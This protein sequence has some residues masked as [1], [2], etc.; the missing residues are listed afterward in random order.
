MASKYWI[1][2]YHEILH[3]RKMAQ[4]SDRLWR[5][6]IE[7]FLFAGEIDDGGA[8]P[9]LDDMAWTLH[10]SP[11]VLETDLGELAKVGITDQRGGKWFVTNF[12]KRQEKMDKAEYMRRLRDERQKDE[13]YQGQEEPLPD[14]YQPVTNGNADTDKIRIDKNRTESLRFIPDH[15]ATPAF[16][17]EW[18]EWQ[19]H[20]IDKGKPLTPGAIQQ[21][22]KN[23]NEWGE[24]RSIAAMKHSRGNNW[25]A[26][27]EPTK[28]GGPSRDSSPAE[29]EIMAH[30]GTYG[31]RQEPSF[32]GDTDKVMRAAGGYRA[33]CKMSEWDAVKAIRNAQKAVKV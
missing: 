23:F 19:Q 15:L 7:F 4:L 26:L 8:L 11:E 27:V 30:I 10:Q 24:A 16:L 9:T 28:K 1:K 31:T 17:N 32:N 2:L 14:S 3:E 12:S 29:A 18:G 5:R 6:S 21:Q 25:A 13:Y 20:H 22:V 33:L